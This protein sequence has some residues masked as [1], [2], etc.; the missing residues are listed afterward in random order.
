MKSQRIR[1][2]FTLAGGWQLQVY[3]PL[4]TWKNITGCRE[5]K[6]KITYKTTLL[7]KYF[8]QKQKKMT[9]LFGKKKN[10][11]TTMRICIQY[12]A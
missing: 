3:F 12:K 6:K 10:K 7:E 11:N 9:G 2:Y 5:N 8:F 1:L 4:C